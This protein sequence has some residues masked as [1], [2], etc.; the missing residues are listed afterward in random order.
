MDRILLLIK[1]ETTQSNECKRVGQ[2]FSCNKNIVFSPETQQFPE[3]AF[4]DSGR[5]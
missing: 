3:R 1:R 5:Y 4:R 2:W